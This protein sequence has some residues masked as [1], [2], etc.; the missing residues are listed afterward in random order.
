MV[1]VVLSKSQ[2][3][4]LK[5][6]VTVGSEESSVLGRSV[7]IGSQLFSSEKFVVKC[8]REIA[9]RLLSVAER[10]CSDV[11]PGIRAAVEHEQQ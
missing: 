7:G 8:T 5:A 3:A 6:A 10:F 1:E 2:L 9:M 11:A 4:C